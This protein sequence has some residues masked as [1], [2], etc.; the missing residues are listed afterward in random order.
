M[1]T[2]VANIRDFPNGLAPNHVY[3]GRAGRGH[4]GYFGNPFVLSRT[5]SR[6]ATIERFRAYAEHRIA[7]D[8]T[9]RARVA[10]LKGK[11]LLCFC[12]P[13]PCHGNVLAELAEGI[14]P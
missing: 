6:G 4:D 10:A 1:T 3:I 7:N 2:R 9:Y 11:T 8:P 14:T 5:E 12:A 13:A